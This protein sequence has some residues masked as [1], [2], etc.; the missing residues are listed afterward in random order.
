MPE[1]VSVPSL[2]P[3]A[4]TKWEP[5]SVMFEKL[6]VFRQADAGGDIRFLVALPP[7]RGL[8]LCAKHLFPLPMSYF[9]DRR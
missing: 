9:K 3:A 8:L 4:T 2:P 1:S 7:L 5:S 6:T